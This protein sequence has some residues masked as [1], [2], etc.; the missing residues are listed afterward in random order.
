MPDYR[1]KVPFYTFPDTL[2]EQEA[3]LDGHPMMERL[4]AS[5]AALASERHRPIYHYVN[6][7]G[8]LNDPNGLCFWQGRWHLFYQAYPPEDPRQHWGHAVSDDLI[9]WRDLPYCIYPHPEEC[10][11]SGAT[12]VEADRVIAMYHGTKVGNMVATASDPLLLNWRKVGDGPVI[13]LPPK[14]SGAPYRVFD[15]CIWR[16]GGWYYALSAGQVPEGPGGTPLAADFLFRSKDLEQW[17]YLHPFTEGDRFTLLGDDGACP[18]FWPIGDKHML[19]FF[20]HMSG[21][22]YLLGNYDTERQ[23][24]V[25]SGAGKF[26]M[27]PVGPGG[28]HAPS[29]TPDGE[30]IVVIFN[31]NPGKRTE[32]WDQIMS[33][34]RRLRLDAEGELCQAPIAAV[35]SC[36]KTRLGGAP[37]S[38][39][40]NEEVVLPGLGGNALEIGATIAPGP[41]SCLELNVLRSPNREEVTRIAFYRDRGYRDNALRRRHVESRITLDT[42]CSSTD[43]S[44]R[45]RAPETASVRLQADEPLELRVFVDRS[46]V[47]VFVNG[48]Q[49]VAA[50][51]YPERDDSTGTSFRSQ[52]SASTLAKLDVWEMGSIYPV[53]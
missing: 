8:R 20:S 53:P 7:E 4:A 35:A 22:Q 5:R 25:V 37:Q 29:A 24:L 41:A 16:Q 6:P 27:G 10:C 11:Y 52:G 43:A 48:R 31:M 32:G 23:K 36:R 44:V 14:G 47:E 40:A 34:P 3:A 33:L 26:N 21:G 12:L 50:R 15:P 38:L 39:P 30:E 13:P 46:I 18:Y 45:C 19:L 17:E 42:S 28:V 51:V 9:H 2:A 1:S 49:C